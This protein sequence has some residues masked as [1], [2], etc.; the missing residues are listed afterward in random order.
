MDTDRT[1]QMKLA[2]E[3]VLNGELTLEQ[4]QRFLDSMEATL[5]Q[6][7]REIKSIEIPMEFIEE[8]RDELETAFTG[9]DCFNDGLAEM[10]QYLYDEDPRH[11]EL[12]IELIEEGNEL[13]RQAQ[14]SSPPPPD[15]TV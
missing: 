11:L 10:R 1:L 15:V 4:Y 14:Q 2:A 6:K 9:I 13:I 3:M 5:T 7:E 12:G 8:L